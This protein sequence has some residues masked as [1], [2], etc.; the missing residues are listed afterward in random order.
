MKKEIAVTVILLSLLIGDL[1]L[2]AWP[3]TFA[4]Q[5]SDRKPPKKEKFGSSLMRLK[6]DPNK[7]A[8]VESEQD[9]QKRNRQIGPGDVIKVETNLVVL[10]LFVTEQTKLRALTGLGKDD[11]VV[12]EDAVT[13]QV[14]MFSVGAD[15][16]LPRSIVLI[17]DFSSSMSRYLERS[18]EAAK[19]LVNR[20][21]PKDEMAIVNDEVEL[22]LGFTG[23]KK[24]LKSALDSLKNQPRGA[25][26]SRQLS[27]LF[28]TLRELSG[29]GQG[30]P[31]IIVQSD[32]DEIMNLRGQ[33]PRAEGQ[34]STWEFGLGDIH[35]A[36]L[37][38]R[39]TI[40]TLIPGERLIGV[41]LEDAR[42]R[43]RRSMV[44]EQEDQY[45]NTITPVRVRAQEAITS[46]ADISGGWA[47]YLES[48][49]RSDE[50][51]ERILADID[52]RYVIGYYPT[53][54]ARDG[55]LRKVQ[56]EVRGH[57]EYVVHGR[58]SYYLTPR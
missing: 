8:A 56:V 36:V 10:D 24:R 57:P 33:Q 7:Q 47:A 4:A 49:E 11:F 45:I 46:V 2:L 17:I 25:H 58:R 28:A 43:V 1:S 34:P 15:P 9:N 53:N 3:S 27:A 29:A 23:D 44:G 30:R 22:M 26:G 19:I 52:Q 54:E 6:W 14:S 18:V 12:T 50:L 55:R 38:T 35:A 42:L 21:G 41:P 20:L 40:Y 5:S 48:P 32:G 51:Y 37:G 13:Q 39:A 16:S 31:I